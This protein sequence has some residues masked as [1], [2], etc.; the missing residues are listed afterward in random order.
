MNDVDRT[1]RAILSHDSVWAAYA[2]ADLRPDMARFCRWLVAPDGSGLALIYS[3]LEPP[4]LLTVGSVDGIAAALN[5]AEL[6]ER[7]FLSVRPEHLP[8]VRRHYPQIDGDEMLRMALPPERDMPAESQTV[9][10]LSRAD[11]HR[12]Q[13]LYR[14]G[15]DFVPDG[16]AAY[17]LD[18]GY[19]FGIED[20]DGALAAAG[21]T[22]IVY[23]LD[24]PAPSDGDDSLQQSGDSLDGIL[25]Q[26]VASIGNVYTRPDY[27]GRG[28]GMAVTNAIIQ[29]LRADG[30]G[31]IVLN[32]SWRNTV[33]RSLYEKLGFV[34]H[35]QFVEGCASINIDMDA[36]DRNAREESEVLS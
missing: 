17:Q 14:H 3:G 34:T 18:D 1:V 12:L 8:V 35:C 28:H 19:F 20:T 5:D 29:A 36:E 13:T 16:F 2:I 21:G 15:G 25:L 10:P 32:V 9:V 6:P 4:I 27:R 23:R 26:G 33:A 22:H 31:L 30:F 7:V 24:R 11:G